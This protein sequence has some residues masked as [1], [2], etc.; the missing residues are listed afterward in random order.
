VSPTLVR[1]DWAYQPSL[2]KIYGNREL[3]PGGG[4][5]R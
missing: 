5:S 1:L 2:E 4:A 3:T